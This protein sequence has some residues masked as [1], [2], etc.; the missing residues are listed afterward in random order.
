MTLHAGSCRFAPSFRDRRRRTVSSV[1]TLLACLA[2]AAPLSARQAFQGPSIHL[3]GFGDASYLLSERETPDGFF[4]GQVV[5]HMNA[6]LAERLAVFGEASATSRSTGFMVEIERLILRYDFADAFKLSAGRYHTP[7]GYW[8]DAFHHGLWLQTS[9]SRPQMIRFGGQLIPVHFV[10]A[11]AEGSFPASGLGLG[12]SLGV[13]NGRGENI[14]RGGDAGD[15]NGHKALLGG[16]RIRPARFRG[17]EVGTAVYVDQ[18]VSEVGLDV[19]ERIVTAHLAWDAGAA[20]VLTEYAHLRHREAVAAASGV[21]S[22]AFYLQIAYRL[23]GFDGALKPYGRVERVDVP[24]SNPLLGTF[25]LDYSGQIIGL[26]YDFSTLAALKV[27]G[28]LERLDGGT[29][30]SSLVVQ[31]SFAIP[32]SGM[33]GSALASAV[34]GARSGARAPG[35]AR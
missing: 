7:L 33:G 3:M 32:G 5:G 17:L 18:P 8:N 22:D 25:G 30:M 21:S 31:G 27:E 23:P 15:V 14:V 26:R 4:L 34:P 24:A 20:E 13:G 9:V 19:E 1:I 6:H 29:R 11:I 10:G 35:S 28:R 12:Y 16:V 2:T